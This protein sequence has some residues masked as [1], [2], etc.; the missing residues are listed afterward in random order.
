[1]SDIQSGIEMAAITQV[2]YILAYMIERVS[3]Y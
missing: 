1:M 2:Y 3:A